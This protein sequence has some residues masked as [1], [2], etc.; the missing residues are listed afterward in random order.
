MIIILL[1]AGAFVAGVV[2][3][4]KVKAFIQAALDKVKSKL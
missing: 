3:A 2:L 4:N 1:L